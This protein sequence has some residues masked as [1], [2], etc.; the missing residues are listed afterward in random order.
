MESQIKKI[1]QQLVS[2]EITC[3]ALVQEKLGLL[4]QN[5]Y[6]SVNSLLDTWALD[7]AAKVDAKI[8]NGETIGLLEGIPFGIKDVFMLQGTLATAS[9]EMLKNYKSPYTATAIQKLLDAGAIPL[10]KE[11]CDSFGHGSSS[12]NTIFGAVKNAID[13]TLVAG[14]SSGGSAVNVA[15]EYTVF[16]IGGD[17]GGSIRQPAGY[18]HIYGFKPTYGRISRFGLMAY[19]SSTDCVGPLAKSIEDIRI[20]LNAMSGKDPKDQTSITSNEISEDAVA[21]S[22]VKTVGYFKN[23]IESEAIDAQIKADFLASIEKIKATGI[24]VVALD[25]FKSDILVSTYYTLAM[26]ETASNLS[27]LDGTN[28]GNRIEAENLIETYAVTRSENFSEETKRR[29]VGGN[30]VLSQGFSD[31][32]YLKGLA[33][34]DQISENFSKDFQEVDIILSPV[35]PSTP[36]KI[37][38]SLKDPLAMYLSDAYTVGFSLGQLPTLTVPQGT[39]TG[40][41][42]TAAKNNDELV[43]QFANFLKDTI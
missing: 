13:P 17:T 3:T 1:H 39:S 9:S 26:A 27:R 2:K 25:F 10:V 5:K 7:L 43:L 22:K 42:I 38:E 15:K 19:T 41:Q 14:G 23:F 21:I 33:V 11:N 12:E 31:E 16:S 24:A 20:V 40:L 32:I 28:Y 34:R 37:G 8:A 18:N 30:Q 36:P 4:Q 35:T 6:N 29:I